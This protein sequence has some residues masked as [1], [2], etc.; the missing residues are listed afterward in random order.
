MVGIFYVLL[1]VYSKKTVTLILLFGLLVQIIDTSAGWMTV[2]NKLT[3]PE[4]VQ[5]QSPLE[6]FFWKSAG[7]TYDLLIAVPAEN[8]Q[9]QWSVW[10]NYAALNHM[11]TNSVFLARYNQ[12]KLAAANDAL[13]E[14]LRTGQYDSKSLY[15]LE[16]DKVIPALL[17][18]DPKKDL[19]AYLDGFYVLA[20]GWQ[21][22]SSCQK[23]PE[24]QVIR[25]ERFI[26]KSGEVIPFGRLEQPKYLLNISQG[27]A[28]PE[29]WGIWSDGVQAQFNLSLPP[30]NAKTLT[31][32]A[33]AFVNTKHPTQEI[34]ITVNGQQRPNITLTKDSNNQIIIPITP[35][36]QA[37]GYLSI[38]FVFKSPA[39]PKDLGMGDDN[40]LLSIGLEKAVFQ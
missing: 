1:Q 9:L 2:R 30:S 17:H 20:P 38:N 32:T 16:I 3:Q 37:A 31:L 12:T 5:W 33:R 10:A 23:V 15:I 24:D 6:S 19:L 11:K 21:S 18:L 40:R 14:R 29:A 22:C 27:W 36:D 28:H 8:N 4:T 25:L 26:S 34:G 39:R 7:K 13:N 35:A